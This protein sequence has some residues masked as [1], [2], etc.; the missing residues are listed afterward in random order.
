V[1][2]SIQAVHSALAARKLAADT[3]HQAAERVLQ[4]KRHYLSW[5]SLPPPTVSYRVGCEVHRQLSALAY[6]CSTTLVRNEDALLPLRFK[7]AEDLLVIYPRS[8]SLT[9]VED[10]HSVQDFLPRSIRLRHLC[11][12]ALP[13]SLCPTES[14]C[15]K[16]IR[17]AARSRVIIMAT[18]NANIYHEQAILMQ[19]LIQTGKHVIG[20]A[21]RNPY[22]ILAFPQL[23][24]YLLTY[25]YTQP[26]LEAAVQVLFG[27]T[28][29]QGRLPV[30]LPLSD[31]Y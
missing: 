12:T 17:A 15:E 30:T 11:T 13:I 21:V 4:L 27:E 16:A 7:S 26:A 2:A 28:L 22:D 29:P 19:Q 23:R 18:M 20:I 25:E 9:M 10:D 6:D 3:I 1:Q 24:T 5:K 14:E 8:Q 31:E